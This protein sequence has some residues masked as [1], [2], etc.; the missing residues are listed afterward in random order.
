MVFFSSVAIGALGVEDLDA[1]GQVDVLRLDLAGAGGDQRRLDLVG[2]GVHADDEVLEVEDDVGDVLLDAR[3][4]GELVR[5]ALDADAGDGG[6]AQRGEQDATEAV[7]E[8]VAEALVEG[9][10]REGAAAVVHFL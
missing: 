6:A 8:G 2:I 5:D 10:D 4:G 9:L 1:G 7:A 3:H